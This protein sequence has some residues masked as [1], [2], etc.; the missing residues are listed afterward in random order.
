MATSLNRFVDGDTDYISKHNSNASLI[1]N[2][3]NRNEMDIDTLK[4]GM[5]AGSDLDYRENNINLLHN[6]NFE[7]W[8]RGT[9]PDRWEITDATIAK[10]LATKYYGA[11][12]LK[13]SAAGYV[14]QTI[15]AEMRNKLK[16]KHITL[17]CWGKT[18][19]VDHCRL[20]INANSVRNYSSYFPNTDTWGNRWVSFYFDAAP[21]SLDV[22]IVTEKAADIYL[23]GISLTFGNPLAGPIY[24]YHGY[25]ADYNRCLAF[26][27][28]GNLDVI[29]A[30]YPVGFTNIVAV[31]I[32]F[33]I[34]KYEIPAIT[35]DG[36][37]GY[38]LEASNIT[39]HGFLLTVTGTDLAGIY[40]EEIDWT[41][42]VAGY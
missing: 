14:F 22:E 15:L 31:W 38:T 7:T 40:A 26:Y 20:A 8:Q 16:G 21:T 41:A 29:G 18:N 42:E 13:I 1:E 3:V 39:K 34:P 33:I 10:D 5:S 36:P 19:M 35:L 4:A 2:G 25:L 24:N 12:S 9:R 11:N 30:G 28:I 32:P 23:S 17:G 27:E 37:T 6:S